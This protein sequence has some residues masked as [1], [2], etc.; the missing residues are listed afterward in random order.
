MPSPR[1]PLELGTG[2]YFITCTIKRW[3][4]LFDRHQRWNIL[5]D[6][7]HY[8]REHKQLRLYAFVF[9]LNHIHMIVASDDVVGF[10]RDFKR[11]TSK[12]LHNNIR[13]TEPNIEVLFAEPDQPYAV[14][15]GTN[16]P[17]R[18]ETDKM[19]VQKMEYIHDNPVRK[20]Y[21]MR[22]EDWYWSSANPRCELVPDSIWGSV[23]HE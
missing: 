4:Y 3:Y 11:H 13:K 12:E 10:L 5:A 1:I 8:C 22:A 20:Q 2:T 6:S 21:V 23:E 17:I 7:L 16:M 18:I 19:L 14:W 9:M 15:Q